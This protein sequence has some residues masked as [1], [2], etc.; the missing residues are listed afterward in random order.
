MFQA[1]CC[2][3]TW[4]TVES[5]GVGKFVHGLRPNR[6]GDANQQHGLDAGDGQFNVA[7]RVVS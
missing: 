3:M 6:H 7:R 4:M 1:Y 2:A 5:F